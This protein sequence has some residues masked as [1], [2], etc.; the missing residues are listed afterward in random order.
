[1]SVLDCLVLL[2]DLLRLAVIGLP[3]CLP[4]WG[5]IL[6]EPGRR[7][8]LRITPRMYGFDVAEKMG[9]VAR[10]HRI[11]DPHFECAHPILEDR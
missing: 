4:G 3:L 1:M 10:V 2:D 8:D 5:Q 9:C 6:P 7:Q 11:Q